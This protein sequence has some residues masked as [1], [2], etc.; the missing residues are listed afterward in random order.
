MLAT[1]LTCHRTS[2]AKSTAGP[3]WE[4]LALPSATSSVAGE[5]AV[6]ALRRTDKKALLRRR[7]R[8]QTPAGSRV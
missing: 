3:V 6:G 7:E 4:T 2:L 5:P 1:G 8:A